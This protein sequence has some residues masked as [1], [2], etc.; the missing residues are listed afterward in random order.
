MIEMRPDFVHHQRGG[1]GGLEGFDFRAQ[2]QFGG[3]GRARSGAGVAATGPGHAV[4]STL[5]AAAAHEEIHRAISRTDHHVSQGERLAGDKFLLHAGVGGA[6]RS[7]VDGIHGAVGPVHD[8]ERILVF[9]GEFRAIAEL[10]ASGAAGADVEHGRHAV[11][12]VGGEFSGTIP[13]AEV[14]PGNGVTD[15]GGAVP[16]QSDVPFHIAVVTEK[17]SVLVEGDVVGVAEAHADEFPGFAVEVGFGDPAGGGHDVRVVSAGIGHAGDELVFSPDFGHA[18]GFGVGDFGEVPG[19][20]VE[21]FAIRSQHNGVWAVLATTVHLPQEDFFVELVISIGVAQ[22]EKATPVAVAHQI[23]RIVGVEQAL[24]FAGFGGE[25]LH[26]GLGPVLQGDAVEAAF[27]IPRDKTLFVINRQTDP[28][29]LGGFGDVVDDFGFEAREHLQVFGRQHGPAAAGKHI[30][31]WLRSQ[32]GDG[33]SSGPAAV[34]ECGLLPALDQLGRKFPGG[35]GFGQHGAA[36]FAVIQPGH[37]AC[38]AAFVPGFHRDHIAAW[39]QEG[40]GFDLERVLPFLGG[41]HG[42]AVQENF[43]VVVAG[44]GEQEIRGDFPDLKSVAEIK[45]LVI[46]RTG[47]PD[48]FRGSGGV[49]YGQRETGK[50]EA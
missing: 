46:R 10:D 50:R 13:E 31:P 40:S 12:V 2:F 22:P 4:E 8:V 17:L 20:D 47:G 35:P 24:G 11:R 29:S 43:R 19:H 45:R 32:L 42:S 33:R 41:A 7:E 5:V 14:R 27:L 21:A 38:C 18:G 1:W 16:R 30:A 9:G 25:Q 23:E 34:I 28:R 39:L 15:A 36:F 26:I 6:I 37:E 49:G 3:R 44:E 48:P